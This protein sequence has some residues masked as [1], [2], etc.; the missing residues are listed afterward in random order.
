[1]ITYVL[2][3]S[4]IGPRK[5]TLREETL[6]DTSDNIM[7]E[8]KMGR[9]FSFISRRGLRGQSLQAIMTGKFETAKSMIFAMP[10]F[11]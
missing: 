1:M 9:Y 8:F 10:F 4:G 7:L 6:T 5:I 3:D 2:N 11:N